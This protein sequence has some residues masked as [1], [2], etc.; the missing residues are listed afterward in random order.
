MRLGAAE[1]AEAAEG[2]MF[3]RWCVAADG[4]TPLSISVQPVSFVNVH[5]Y[6]VYEE[7]EARASER[8]RHMQSRLCAQVHFILQIIY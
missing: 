8:Y 5:R 7:R 1:A 4:N 2:A 6:M 3:T